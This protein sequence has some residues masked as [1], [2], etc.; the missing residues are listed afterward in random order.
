MHGCWQQPPSVPRCMGPSVGNLE[1]CD[2]MTAASRERG[3]EAA[4]PLKTWPRKS[5]LPPA[6]AACQER[7]ASAHWRGEGGVPSPPAGRCVRTVGTSLRYGVACDSWGESLKD[8][9]VSTWN[10]SVLG[11]EFQKRSSVP[12][13]GVSCPNQRQSGKD[14]VNGCCA[15]GTPQIRYWF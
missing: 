12:Q 7:G 1:W 6:C 4:V 14:G 13:T 11:A 2:D 3:L 10:G 8:V 9:A 15:Q 5:H